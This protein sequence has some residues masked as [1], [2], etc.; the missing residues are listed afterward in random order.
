MPARALP[1]GALL[2]NVVSTSVV[3]SVSTSMVV[4]TVFS[5]RIRSPR[6]CQPLRLISSSNLLVRVVQLAGSRPTPGCLRCPWNIPFISQRLRTPASRCTRRSS[7]MRSQEPLTAD[8]LGGHRWRVAVPLDRRPVPRAL[9]RS[10]QSPLVSSGHA[11]RAGP[12]IV[13]LEWPPQA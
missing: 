11:V 12:C 8:T 2:Y 9:L 4:A 7:A 10:G 6:C 13:C 3:S 1:A 5:E